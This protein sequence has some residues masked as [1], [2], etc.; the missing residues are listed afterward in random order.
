MNEGRHRG[1][2]LGHQEVWELIPWHVNGTLGEE[3][4]RQVEAHLAVCPICREEVRNS[5]RLAAAV[6][7]AAVE[8]TS[9]ARVDRGLAAVMARIDT[10]SEPAADDT[11]PLQPRPAAGARARSGRGW[12]ARLAP[13]FAGT[14]PGVRWAL[15]LQAAA[16]LLLAGA[17]L[18]RPAP[19]PAL[20]HTLSDPRVEPAA[21]AAPDRLR[22]RVTF[23]E[24]ATVEELRQALSELGAEIVAGPS[25]T[26]VYTVE[27]T[28]RGAIEDSLVERFR[29]RPV[30][31]FATPVV[32]GGRSSTPAPG[33]AGRAER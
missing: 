4:T 27:V 6:G 17:L 15:A 23:D 11:A 10:G 31:Q 18:G 26:G 20:F 33:T 14:P 19:A 8:E 1:G 32:R 24:H 21:P 30:I 2:E 13:L 12:R 29:A 9:A 16:L 7:G 3:E 28:A 25:P 22:L 5:R